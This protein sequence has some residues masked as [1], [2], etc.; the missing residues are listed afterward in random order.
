MKC[1]SIFCIL[2]LL[3]IP[4]TIYGQDSDSIFKLRIEGD[5]VGSNEKWFY[6]IQ[7]QIKVE[8][9]LFSQESMW[10][11]YSVSLKID[12]LMV[13]SQVRKFQGNHEEAARLQKKY[14]KLLDLHV[15]LI[16]EELGTQGQLHLVQAQNRDELKNFARFDR[17][18]DDPTFL[19]VRRL[20]KKL[21]VTQ[22]QYQPIQKKLFKT[23]REILEKSK[24]EFDTLRDEHLKRTIQ[25]LNSRQKKLFK[26][27]IGKPLRWER[28]AIA[29][30]S[31]EHSIAVLGQPA[32][33]HSVLLPKNKSVEWK[34]LKDL[35]EPKDFEK[36]KIEL[37]SYL[38]FR[39]L[40]SNF[41]REEMEVTDEQAR[42]FH[43]LINEWRESAVI[44]GKFRKQR[45]E[46]LI[47]REAK[48][49]GKLKA[50]ILSHQLKW[51][52]TSELQL[53]TAR[54]RFSFGL[55]H[56]AMVKE[57][58]LDVDQQEALKTLST[59]YQQSL[60]KLTNRLNTKISQATRSIYAESF[61]ILTEKQKKQYELITGIPARSPN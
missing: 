47:K 7:N 15:P 51:L 38:L 61:K 24:K 32:K 14:N 29:N 37:V 33:Y 43:Q 19:A 16:L 53:Y 50:I 3:A 39:I 42:K 5:F 48:Y 8:A 25:V 27:L 60:T 28:L 46:S 31:F 4:S 56:P 11:F 17:H 1:P 49:P 35:K 10:N 18:L 34:M 22:K 57:L 6:L 58:K 55:L 20:R 36:K 40:A 12:A 9:G 21:G 41:F 59:K 54:F 45:M 23:R 13:E 26:Q 30:E 2:T 44:S 52:K